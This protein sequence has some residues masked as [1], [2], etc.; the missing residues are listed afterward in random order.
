MKVEP[1]CA[2]CLLTRGIIQIKMSTED[3]EKR[4]QATIKLLELLGKKFN[5]ESIP[6]YLGTEREILLHEVTGNNDPYL[7]LKKRSNKIGLE[8]IQYLQKE[9]EILDD[10]Q[11]FRKSLIY[12]A[13]SNSIEFNIKGH[14]IDLEKIS[15]IIKLAEKEIIIDDSK[16]IFELLKKKPK[17]LFLCDNAGEIAFD[18]LVVK[19]IKKMGCDI[20]VVVRGGPVLN[21]ALL[22]DAT[23]VG[24]DKITK[25][26]T[27]GKQAIGIPPIN[28]TS[29]EFQEAYNSAELII[30]KGMGNWESLPDLKSKIPVAYILRT[31]CKPVARSLE[32]EFQKNVIKLLYP[33]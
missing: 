6:A 10:Y 31:K 9:V 16:E 7:E 5:I 14:K 29:E 3:K 17:V 19:Q 25:V 33:E 28:E 26:I 21:D 2:E 15:E 24:I 8:I 12:S 32:T 4:I 1:E 18:T 27:T 11:M 30:S 13:A 23:E 22:E 20:T